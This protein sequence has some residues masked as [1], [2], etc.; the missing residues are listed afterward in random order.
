[1]FNNN[2]IKK[3][4]SNFNLSL[5][6][7]DKV[8]L[9]FHYKKITK[10]MYDNLQQEYKISVFQILKYANCFAILTLI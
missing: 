7:V 6:F 3:K 5:V 8:I 1:M 10:K 4:K 9:N 2:T